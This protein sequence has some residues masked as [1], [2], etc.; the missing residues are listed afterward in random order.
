M[1]RI[2]GRRTPSDVISTADLAEVLSRLP[3]GEAEARQ[4]MA[5]L[6]AKD[7]VGSVYAYAALARVTDDEQVRTVARTRCERMA[8]DASLCERGFIPSQERRD[9]VM[10]VVLAGLASLVAMAGVAAAA[11]ALLRVRR[12]A[13]RMASALG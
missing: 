3:E 10:P 4:L 6:V 8:V 1:R 13:A 11:V 7:L 5:P 12:R 2:R 9:R